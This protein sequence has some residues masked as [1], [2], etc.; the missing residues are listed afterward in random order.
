MTFKISTAI[1]II[2]I[3]LLLMLPPHGILNLLISAVA[4]IA[5]PVSFFSY[6]SEKASTKSTQRDAY[7]EYL[8]S[9][10]NHKD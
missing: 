1:S 4:I 5:L 2:A 3:A 10:G 8:R 7:E 9:L 6:V